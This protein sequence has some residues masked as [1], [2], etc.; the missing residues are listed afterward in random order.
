M[1]IE[2]GKES[3]Q[4]LTNSGRTK[5]EVWTRVSRWDIIDQCHTTTLVK[6]QNLFLEKH[7]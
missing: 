1:D 2:K 5:C 7:L 3:S 6:N 4:P